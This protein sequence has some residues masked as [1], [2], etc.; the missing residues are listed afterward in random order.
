MNRPILLLHGGAWAMPD[1]AVAAHKNGI[2]NA[3][4]AGWAVLSR[5]GSALDAVE[6][7]ITLM[8]DDDTFDA[9]RGSFLTRDGRVQ[10]DALLMSGAD[11]RAGGVA[12]VER[13][14]NPIQAARLVL[15]HS[16]H[17][18]FTGPGAE[19]FAAAHGMPLI[20]NADLVVPREQARLEAFQQA[21]AAG[22]PD[23]TFAGSTSSL[24]LDITGPE[25]KTGAARSETSRSN[26]DAGL[27]Q[28]ALE[29]E[30]NQALPSE[31][32][33]TDPTLHS[34]DT[35]GALALD[36]AGNLAAGTS[37]GGTLSKMPG[38]VGDSSLI[39]CGC[40]A[41][42]QSAA[43]SLTG[44]GEPI[45]KLVLGKWAADR[46]EAGAAPQ[47]AA[48]DAIAYLHRRLGGHG[49]IILL[50]PDGRFGIAHNT[51]RMAWGYATA[52]G[53]QLGIDRHASSAHNT[54]GNLHPISM[55]AERRK[56]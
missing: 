24:P 54:A 32:Q 10:L 2:R 20:R 41:D 48:T 29:A 55:S 33:F 51:P 52:S 36:A 8:E 49:G 18:Y 39:G 19:A 53:F 9:G 21:Q 50:G 56:I 17:V 23:L 13:L 47:T 27:A 7:A 6:T 14:R 22:L 30:M 31:L 34:H 43:A 12:S 25:S 15:D 26:T 44:W 46:V 37:T 4:A 11:L 42:N 5:G 1:D 16:P 45:M 38:R 28:I 3:L 35:V 40:Y